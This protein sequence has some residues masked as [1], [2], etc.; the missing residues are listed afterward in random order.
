[1]LYTY[2]VEQARSLGIEVET[3][4]FQAFMQVALVG[5]GPVTILLDSRAENG[6][7]P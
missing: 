7:R 5:N 3:G 6:E 2:F 4:R 1:M